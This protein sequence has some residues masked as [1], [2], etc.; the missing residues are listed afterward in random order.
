MN[1]ASDTLNEGATLLPRSNGVPA[2]P[3]DRR[4]RALVHAGL[5]LIALVTIP[6][7]LFTKHPSQWIGGELPR[8]PRKAADVILSGAPIIVCPCSPSAS[9][10]C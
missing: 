6:S 8:D 4:Y 10:C 9:L 1:P 2:R 5:I 3:N 7:F